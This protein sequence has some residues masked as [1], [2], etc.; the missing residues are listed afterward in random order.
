MQA[1]HVLDRDEE[2]EAE[3][4]FAGTARPVVQRGNPKPRAV[5][6]EGLEVHRDQPV[7]TGRDKPGACQPTVLE[8]RPHGTWSR[9]PASAETGSASCPPV[10]PPNPEERRYPTTCAIR[11]TIIA[12]RLAHAAPVAS[13]SG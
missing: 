10:S 4:Q 5:G 13:K 12:S 1:G 2:R 3:I 6:R 11:L 9:P 7:A 8:V